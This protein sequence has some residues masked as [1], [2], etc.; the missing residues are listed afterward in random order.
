MEGSISITVIDENDF[1]IVGLCKN[2]KR[3]NSEFLNGENIPLS[4]K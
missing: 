3:L 2:G 1:N 4:N